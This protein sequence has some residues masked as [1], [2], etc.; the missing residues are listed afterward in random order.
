MKIAAIES[1]RLADGWL[2]DLPYAGEK[3]L[4]SSVTIDGKVYIATFT[5]SNLVS[6]INSCVPRSG[7]GQLY[8]MDIYNGDRD[9]VTL[10]P[11]IPDTPAL[12]F[13]AEGNIII[14]AASWSRRLGCGS[15]E[16]RVCARASAHRRVYTATLW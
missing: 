15:L 7:T 8:V 3:S 2:F 9:V 16:V 12:Y 6:D 5:P 10:G 11:I 4:A 13:T 14:L 1:L